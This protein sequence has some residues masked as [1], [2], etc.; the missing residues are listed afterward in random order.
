MR[1][2]TLDQ[3]VPWD[4]IPTSTHWHEEQSHWSTTQYSVDRARRI[5]WAVSEKDSHLAFVLENILLIT[6]T[7]T[8]MQTAHTCLSPWRWHSIFTI[9][10]YCYVMICYNAEHYILHSVFST[11]LYFIWVWSLCFE[12]QS[13]EGCGG[14]F[15]ACLQ[16]TEANRN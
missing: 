5:D 8:P 11:L 10:S 7:N 16:L 4:G 3:M 13:T 2:T 15:S 14:T 12:S 9:C 1:A 6:W